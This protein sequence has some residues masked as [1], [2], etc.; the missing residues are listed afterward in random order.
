M[1][2]VSYRYHKQQIDR[3]DYLYPT[4]VRSREANTMITFLQETPGD[5]AKRMIGNREF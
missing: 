3:A 4:R 1:I 2:Y 5:G